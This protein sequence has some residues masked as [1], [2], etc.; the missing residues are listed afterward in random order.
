MVRALVACRGIEDWPVETVTFDLQYDGLKI[1]MMDSASRS[2][3]ISIRLNIPRAGSR[4]FLQIFT[5][6]PPFAM[7]TLILPG[8]LCEGNA[9]ALLGHLDAPGTVEEM[10]V[11]Q[12]FVPIF[13]AIIYNQ[14]RKLREI[15]G[16]K[17]ARDVGKTRKMDNETKA[18]CWVILTFH[19]LVTLEY[20]G[21]PL[22][23]GAGMYPEDPEA[24]EGDIT[25]WWCSKVLSSKEGRLGRK[26][27][28]ILGE[29]LRWRK[30]VGLGV[31]ELV[32]NNM[33]VPL[34][35][36][37]LETLCEGV[38]VKCVDVVH[39]TGKGEL[40]KVLGFKVNPNA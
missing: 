28:E 24:E 14:N 15:T 10:K 13:T 32:F 37:D 2:R 27:F 39:R 40:S 20:Y 11:L 34:A 1:Q 16:F 18:R 4:R 12:V 9:S 25:A 5:I 21:D 6:L 17:D 3:S 33:N 35:R 36:R 23:D 7:K 26:Y 19:T 31:K 22:A 8:G 38:E 29:W 30:A